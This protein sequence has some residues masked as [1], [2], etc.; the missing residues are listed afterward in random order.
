MALPIEVINK[1]MLIKIVGSY[2][3]VVLKKALKQFIEKNSKPEKGQK[4]YEN[5][6]IYNKMYREVLKIVT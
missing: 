6:K 4:L 2:D 5:W 3:F 1:Y